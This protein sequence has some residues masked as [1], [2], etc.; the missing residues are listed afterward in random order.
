MLKNTYISI[1][2]ILSIIFNKSLSL[3]KLPTIW[4]DAEVTPLQKKGFQQ[5]EENYRPIS[6]LSMISK[7]LERCK[8]FY[9]KTESFQTFKQPSK[10]A[11]PP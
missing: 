2:P 3:G 11:V 8:T 7:C 6:L 4:K 9:F 1:T 5:L 10:K